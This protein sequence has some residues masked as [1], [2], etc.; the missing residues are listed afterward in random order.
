MVV[1][2]TQLEQ[3]WQNSGVKGRTLVTFTRYL[4]A[5]E[6]KD[7]KEIEATER[8]M[9]KGIIRRVFHIVPD[10]VWN[11]VSKNLSGRVGMRPTPEGFIGIFEYGRV[12]ILPLSRFSP[13]TEKSLL[14]VEPKIWS[15]AELDKIIANLQ[16]GE[17]AADLVAVIRGTDQDATNFR[18]ALQVR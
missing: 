5:T 18:R 9:E 1:S 16:S 8:A 3:L 6:S 17:L 14:V 11:E 7:T 2:S 4:N 13:P 15:K 12:Y 10:H